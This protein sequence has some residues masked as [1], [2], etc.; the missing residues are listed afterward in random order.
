M[1][2]LRDGSY[3]LKG[4]H[5]K[6]YRL[7]VSGVPDEFADAARRLLTEEAHELNRDELK[8]LADGRAILNRGGAA[9]AG[10]QGPIVRFDCTWVTWD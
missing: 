5:G 4:P 8:A 3:E 2:D 10:S 7:E 1:E 6:E 9:R